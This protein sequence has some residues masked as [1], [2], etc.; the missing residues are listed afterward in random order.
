MRR[1][2]SRNLAIPLVALFALAFQFAHT[3]GH[4]HLER[5][6]DGALIAWGKAATTPAA[7]QAPAQDRQNIRDRAS[8]GL[9][10]HRRC[11]G[12]AFSF[13]R[14]RASVGLTPG[15]LA[16]ERLCGPHLT[17]D[18][19]ARGAMSIRDGKRKA[20]RAKTQ[21]NKTQINTTAPR[22]LYQ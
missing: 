11:V 1:F 14:P 4:V 22:H 17:Q 12:R 20:A 10:A 13:R 16:R 21:I 2:R 18:L 9:H 19:F 6:A 3:F 15:A 5:F 7:E 8:V